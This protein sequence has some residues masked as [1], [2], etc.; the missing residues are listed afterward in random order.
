[1]CKDSLQWLME[2]EILV[3]LE[4]SSSR[5]KPVKADNLKNHGTWKIDEK[6]HPAGH[7]RVKFFLCLH[8]NGPQWSI[9]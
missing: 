6:S 5:L 3:Q 4:G 1:M 7:F 2:A 8:P 9:K